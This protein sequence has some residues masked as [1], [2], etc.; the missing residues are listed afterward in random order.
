MSTC[1]SS[2]HLNDA[3]AFTYVELKEYWVE[4]FRSGR[5]H[6]LSRVERGFYKACM[7]FARVKGVILSPRLR[8]MLSSIIVKLKPLR[9]KALE[10]GMKR[11]EELKALFKRS[12]VFKW[13]PRV[14][15]WLTD[16]AYILYLGFMEIYTPPRFAW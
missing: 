10:A 7:F 3:G 15:E 16:K 5:M 12:G 2:P 9:L 1:D 11:V 4:G 8:S 6:S 14:R 13:A